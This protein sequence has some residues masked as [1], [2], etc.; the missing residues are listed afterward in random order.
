MP[1]VGQEL[2]QEQEPEEDSLRA[3][4]ESA[5]D[6]DAI[7]GEVETPTPTPTDEGSGE[8]EPAPIGDGTPD[9]SGEATP[10]PLAA[11]ENKAPSSWSPTAREAWANIPPEVQTEIGRREKEL[12]NNLNETTQ[13]RQLSQNFG[14]LVQP[15]QGMFQAQGVDVFTGIN[16]TLQL[17]AQL[18]MGTPQQK[19]QACA[20]IIQ[21]F[22]VDIGS[23]DD[24]LVGKAPTQQQQSPEFQQMQTQMNQMGQYIQNQQHNQQ[25]TQQ[26]EQARINTETETFIQSKPYA[27]DMR[28]LMADFMD[29]AQNQN[30]PIT[31]QVAY[32]RAL[33]TRPD[34]QK[35]IQNSTD[36][37]NNQTALQQAQNASVSLPQETVGGQG[38]AP[39]TTMRGALEDAWNEA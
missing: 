5:F 11:D 20:N 15:Y 17:A 39:A 30:Q 19:A 33:G 13:A 24:L 3:S 23:L 21:Q 27:N 22:G 9:L 12:Q 6:E 31:L 38:K 2:E 1:P 32:D 25:V 26:Q 14:N 34:I 10:T 16:N 36:T 7:E 8:V 29:M 4:L 37:Q 28:N 35:L 18:Q